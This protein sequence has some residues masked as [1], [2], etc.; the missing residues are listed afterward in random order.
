MPP[1]SHSRYAAIAYLLLA[2]IYL[3]Y[4]PQAQFLLDDWFVL[5]KYQAA[6][7]A[8]TAEQFRVFTAYLQNQFH[9][10]FRFQWLSFSLGY[11]LWL[12]AGYSPGVMFTVFLISHTA[13]AMLLRDVGERIGIGAG[14]AFLS[15]VVFLLLPT[16]HGAL[17]WSFNCFYY[18]WSTFW[19]LLYLRSLAPALKA[20]KLERKQ[21]VEQSFFLLLALFSGDP[22]FALLVAGAPLLAWFLRSKAGVRATLLAWGTVG[23]AATFY[24]LLINKARMFEHGVGLRYDFSPANLWANLGAIAHTYA[25]L[26]GLGA[27]AFYRFRPSVAGV[28]AGI[29]AA[30]AVLFVWR[31]G[32]REAPQAGQGAGCGPGGPPHH[33]SILALWMAFALWVVAYGPILFLKGHELRYSYVPSPYLALAISIVVCGLPWAR[34]PAAVLTAWLAVATVADIE[35][36]WIPQSRNLRAFGETLRSFRD[37]KAGDLFIVAGTPAWIGTA[38]DFA[39]GSGGF[40]K[41]FAEHVTGTPDLRVGTDIVS[42][43]G[44]LRVF[45]PTYIRDMEP[46]EPHRTRALVMEADGRF[47]ERHLLAQEV[48]PGAYRLYALKGYAGPPPPREP[49]SREQLMLLETEIYFAKPYSH[50]KHE[51]ESGL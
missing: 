30:V 3:L 48:H 44:R 19:F 4:L 51:H 26:T 18:V 12:L 35:Q 2:S 36:C 28:A 5:G 40:S 43:S 39:L 45:D 8:G 49:L 7:E 38:P 47:T 17:F 25:R 1:G 34:V 24:A 46:A 27:D 10:Q 22:I 16:T 20:G 11:V 9:D 6:R 33:K 32:S 41:P 15:G 37:V 23:V 42:E 13:C 14:A 50:A 29:G 21:A 31:A